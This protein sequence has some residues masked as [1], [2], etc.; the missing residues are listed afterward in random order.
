MQELA[1]YTIASKDAY[2]LASCHIMNVLAFYC[3]LIIVIVMEGLDITSTNGNSSEH[4][5]RP[6]VSHEDIY[7][8]TLESGQVVTS[9]HEYSS[10][11]NN[12]P[13]KSRSYIARLRRIL[14]QFLSV[15]TFQGLPHI[16]NASKKRSYCRLVYWTT[17][18][19]IAI[20]LMTWAVVSVTLEFAEMTTTLQ[21]RQ[22]YSSSI[23]FPA[24][25]IC[26]QNL[27]RRSVISKVTNLTDN[28]MSYL[29]LISGNNVLLNNFNYREFLHQYA[30]LLGE[31]SA[32]YYNNSGHQLEDMLIS[33]RYAG[34]AQQCNFTR[35]TSSSGNCYTLNSGH[36]GS[37]FYTTEPGYWYGLELILNAEEHEYFLAESDSVGFKV[38]IHDQD[39]FPYYGAVGSFLVSS[40]QFTQVVLSRVN[41]KLLTPRSGGQCS[42]EIT[43]KYFDSYSMISCKSEC[44]TDF[45][46]ELCNC[47]GEF[48]PGPAR[49]CKLTDTCLFENAVKFDINQCNCPIGCDFSTNEK[50]LSY[51][52]YPA[53]HL[54]DTLNNSGSLA[55]NPVLP[56]FVISNATDKNGSSMFYLNDKFDE[57]FI[58][59][60]LAKLRIYYDNLLVV[61][62]E[63]IL[64]YTLFQFIADFG[65]HIGL[66][67]GAGFLTLFEILEL[68]F[69]KSDD[70]D[71]IWSYT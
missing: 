22:I 14:L 71:S 2:I 24:V 15:T 48:M 26:N 70:D 51:G 10:H 12:Q 36:D 68:C 31:D 66:F 55:L 65:G 57:S 23:I 46:V 54:T 34:E 41:Y 40:G 7:L 9:D 5:T 61:T 63:E 47:K 56:D 32:F 59:N 29:N 28:V 53:G 21:S 60:N 4:L 33:C 1:G 8:D 25:T 62:N 42:D 35:Q 11:A 19:F 52:K 13:F 38:Y 16:A 44:L 18:I 37:I 43:L 69:I 64:D 6:R 17:L 67:T 58:R 20:G 39:H 27:F 45:I 49:V 3:S 30:D 50:T